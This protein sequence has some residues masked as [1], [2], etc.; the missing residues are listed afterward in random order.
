M[1]FTFSLT[2]HFMRL[3]STSSQSG[4]VSHLSSVEVAT[5]L[6]LTAS[7]IITAS[8]GYVLPT[9]LA[10]FHHHSNDIIPLQ[11]IFKTL[12]EQLS[13]DI[14]GI[15]SVFSISGIQ[16]ITTTQPSVS[17]IVVFSQLWLIFY[18]HSAVCKHRLV[19]H[20]LHRC[21]SGKWVVF[22]YCHVFDGINSSLMFV[23]EHAWAR[24]LY[25]TDLRVF[26]AD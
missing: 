15:W 6:A 21:S 2:L 26:L 11:A 25:V 1:S 13:N 8:C 19:L 4:C 9:I 23:A 14:A 24:L 12:L 20:V 18:R 17:F 16:I 22:P 3:I 7:R 10:E 5:N